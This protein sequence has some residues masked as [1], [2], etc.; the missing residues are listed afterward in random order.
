MKEH[1]ENPS[2]VQIC[3]K[4][5]TIKVKRFRLNVSKLKVKFWFQET[6]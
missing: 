4:P 3:V 1:Y 6:A 5:V 2:K